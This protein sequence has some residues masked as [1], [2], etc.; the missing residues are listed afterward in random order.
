MGLVLSS[1]YQ[2]GIRD[3][4]LEQAWAAVLKNETG[5]ESRPLGVGKA[6]VKV[7]LDL[8]Y[9]PQ[10]ASPNL[11]MAA[12]PEGSQ[13]S[14][15]HTLE[16][17]FSAYA[18]AQLAQ[19]LGK[20]AEYERFM[21]LAKGWERLFDPE[22]GFI[23]PKDAQGKFITDFDPKKAWHG[24]QEGNAYQYTFYV[25]HD[26]AGLIRKV[27]MEQFNQ[28]LQSTFEQAEKAKF[29]GGEPLQSRQPTLAAYCLAI[30][31]QRPSVADPALGTE[32]LRRLLWD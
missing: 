1:A 26:P 31:L 21:R 23:R 6:D 30:Q 3:Y 17:S 11:M 19:A 14:A 32:N 13:Y 8:G 18:A 16:Y 22:T 7:F 27:G 12:T 9:V 15:S 29:G 24:F 20:P 4:D 5:W 2:W 28:R 25:P 10:I